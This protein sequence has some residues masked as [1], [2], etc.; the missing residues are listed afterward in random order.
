METGTY[1]KS[2]SDT[3]YGINYN[4]I[5]ENN[6]LEL[7]RPMPDIDKLDIYSNNELPSKTHYGDK[8]DN[9]FDNALVNCIGQSIE[10]SSMADFNILQSS[11]LSSSSGCNYFF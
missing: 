4:K 7:D 3:N 11:L 2:L 9:F 5:F 1:C 10:T 6:S 8:N